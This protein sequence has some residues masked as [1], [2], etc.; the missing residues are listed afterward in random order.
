MVRVIRV[1]SG[2]PESCPRESLEALESAEVRIHVDP[3]HPSFKWLAQ[4]GLECEPLDAESVPDHAALVVPGDGAIGS[5]DGFAAPNERAR[6]AESLEALVQTVDRLLG[7]GGCPWDQEQTHESLKRHLIEETYEVLDAIESRSSDRLRDELGD[8]LLQPVMHAQ[9]ARLEGDFAIEDVA[10][11]ARKKLIRRHPHVFGTLSAEDSDE[12]LRNWDRIKLAE[13]SSSADS[14]G[15]NEEPSIL[16]G[17][18]RA[19]PSL[20]RSYVMSKR[21][22]RAGFEWPDFE[23][24]LDKMREEEA[25]LTAARAE[26]G[27]EPSAQVE[28]EVGD[29]L[30]TAVNVARWCGVEPEEALRK[31][32]DRFE[33][34]FRYME[35]EAPGSFD[36]LTADDWD[37]LWERS[38][39]ALSFG[40]V[41]DS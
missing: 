20:L 17:I 39:S 6:R 22:A 16:D 9:M 28:A 19:M 13:R 5:P 24:V 31:M 34:R 37:A 10:E 38:K 35:R 29:L 7:P 23:S 40:S 21:A 15:T 36:G 30:F 32:L 25:E 11:A 26:S 8:L 33:A 14:A 2:G 18:P 1:G 41:D 3:N 27:E 4:I 12:V